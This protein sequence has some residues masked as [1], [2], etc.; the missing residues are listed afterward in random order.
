M[1][2]T[3]TND[4]RHPDIEAEIASLASISRDHIERIATAPATPDAVHRHLEL[5]RLQDIRD[6][7]NALSYHEI[8]GA[9]KTAADTMT[10]QYLK[11]ADAIE[12]TGKVYEEHHSELAERLR[13]EADHI[14]AEGRSVREQYDKAAFEYRERANAIAAELDHAGEKSDRAIQLCQEVV[15]VLSMA[16]KHD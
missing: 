13:H 15:N 14:E 1:T 4:E 3:E 16:I 10:M 2:N 6:R 9:G 5:T 11:T 7:T 8:R 12:Q